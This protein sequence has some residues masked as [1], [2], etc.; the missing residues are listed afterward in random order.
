[1]SLIHSSSSGDEEG[2]RVGTPKHLDQL[3]VLLGQEEV[4]LSSSFSR[5]VVRVMTRTHQEALENRL[6][7]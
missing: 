1:M 6:Y 5:A 4:V 2:D 7:N 3:G